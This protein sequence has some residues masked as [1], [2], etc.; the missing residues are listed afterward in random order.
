VFDTTGPTS[1]SFL[2][3][4]F[5][6]ALWANGEDGL[7]CRPGQANV[8][9]ATGLSVSAV[10]DAGGVALARTRGGERSEPAAQL[11]V[12]RARPKARRVPKAGMSPGDVLTAIYGG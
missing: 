7:C 6:L 12:A 2:A 11:R 5:F 4:A 9:A 1:P 3:V 8:C 10:L